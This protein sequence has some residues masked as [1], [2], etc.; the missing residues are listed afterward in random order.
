M[1]RRGTRHFCA[2]SGGGELIAH[3]ARIVLTLPDS[4]QLNLESSSSRKESRPE[5]LFLTG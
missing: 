1:P 4:I 5:P 2:V 3:E